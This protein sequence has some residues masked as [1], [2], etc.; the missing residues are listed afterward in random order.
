MHKRSVFSWSTETE[1]AT[2]QERGW[3]YRL[4]P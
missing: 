4:L 3:T 2:M 1:A